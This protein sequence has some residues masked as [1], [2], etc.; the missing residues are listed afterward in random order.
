MTIDYREYYDLD[1]YLFG[2]AQSLD[3]VTRHFE[4]EGILSAFD[5]F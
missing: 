1:Q 3:C 4:T 2:N 5:F